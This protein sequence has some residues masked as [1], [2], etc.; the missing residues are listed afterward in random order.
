M[1]FGNQFSLSS[2]WALGSNSGHQIRW[3]VSLPAE[4]SC[5]LYSVKSYKNVYLGLEGLIPAES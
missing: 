4:P 5:Q 3:Q 2:M 1:T